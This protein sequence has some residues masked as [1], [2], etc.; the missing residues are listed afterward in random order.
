L[1]S[2]T[3]ESSIFLFPDDIV[4]V[5]RY[6]QIRSKFAFLLHP[7]NI[8]GAEFDTDLRE[9]EKKARKIA[10]GQNISN[11]V[12]QYLCYGCITGERL[13]VYKRYFECFYEYSGKRVEYSLYERIW[14]PL[15]RSEMTDVMN[16]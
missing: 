15:I 11:E 7:E 12:E 5:A 14:K 6:S 3:R 16:S 8:I 4:R 1:A 9:R 2:R 10:D 13:N